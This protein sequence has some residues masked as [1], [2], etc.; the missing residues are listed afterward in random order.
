M[1]ILGFVGGCVGVSLGE[2]THPAAGS[3]DLTTVVSAGGQ[4]AACKA[5][6]GLGVTPLKCRNLLAQLTSPLEAW[7]VTLPPPMTGAEVGATVGAVVGATV[8]A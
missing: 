3:Y 8:G 2:G 7:G 6:A 1:G 4:V 5:R